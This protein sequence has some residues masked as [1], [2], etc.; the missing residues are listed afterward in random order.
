MNTKAKH[1]L[2]K[3]IVVFL[4]LIIW[5][6]ISLFVRNPI[7]IAGPVKTLKAFCTDVLKT[8]FW[9]IIG[10]SLLKYMAGLFAGLLVGILFAIVSYRNNFIRQFLVPAVAF[11]KAVPVAGFAVLLLIWWGASYL[12]VA[13][14]F[15]VTFP[16]FY[17]STLEGLN[18]SDAKLLEM[19]QVFGFTK[20]AQA[21]YIYKEALKPFW[22]SAMKT[23]VGMSVKAGVA[24]EVI[25][26]PKHSLGNALYESK[27]YLETD[28]VFS[29]I[30]VIILVGMC[31]EKI[32][33]KLL[34]MVLEIAP[35]VAAKERKGVE[36]EKIQLIDM[37][38]VFDGQMIFSHL[39]YT[40][41]RGETVCLMAPSG[42]G[43]T[44]LLRML[45]GL[46]KTEEGKIEWT[47]KELSGKERALS[48][49]EKKKIRIGM[50]FQENRL[51]EERTAR[52]N[53]EI[54]ST[55]KKAG[56]LLS[57][58]FPDEADTVFDKKVKEMS[59][60]MKRRVSVARALAADTDIL[61][62]DEPFTGLD[63]DNKKRVVSVI[64][65]YQN[66]RILIVSTHHKED[67]E[68]L[69]AKVWKMS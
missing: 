10:S 49:E 21:F 37:E 33:L 53:V 19:A 58:L 1:I 35:N 40:F 12:S 14:S 26:L 66:E 38:K 52:K 56:E 28:H 65:E 24:A 29:W 20:K 61:L 43:K 11:A 55:S 9:A 4:W 25:G 31:T 30:F 3:C 57:K 46:E 36:I 22:K 45:T 63:E 15:L 39:N 62:L 17:V 16:F 42:E 6:M 68:I 41:K 32:L 48:R 34:D 7:L 51:F 8:T 67:A 69:N 47:G 50:V 27:I 59:G 18:N 13:I 54:V 2:Q 5:Q 44:T 64:K 23:C 60:G